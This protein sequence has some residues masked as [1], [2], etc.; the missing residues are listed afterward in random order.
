MTGMN[1]EKDYWANALIASSDRR[2]RRPRRLAAT[3]TKPMCVAEWQ[4]WLAFRDDG[5]FDLRA[6]LRNLEWAKE[7]IRS[8][9]AGVG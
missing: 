8:T 9:I 1:R 5:R 4:D 7:I 3:K 2:L 6:T